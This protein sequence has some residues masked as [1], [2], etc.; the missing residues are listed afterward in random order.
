M[1][2]YAV[3]KN[4]ANDEILALHP[5]QSLAELESTLA[6]SAAAFNQWRNTEMA[7]PV[8]VFRQLAE[9]LRKR[10]PELSRMITPEMG[11][12]LAQARAEILKYPNLSDWYAEH[13]PAMQEDQPTQVPD[14]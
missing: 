2:D 4:P 7:A 6:A 8:K 14:A 11:K 12:P 10:E 1:T 3:S 9:Q 5:M 13:G